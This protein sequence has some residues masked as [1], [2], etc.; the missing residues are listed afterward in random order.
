MGKPP[1]L[2]DQA[3]VG[4]VRP[5]TG[6]RVGLD[7]VRPALRIAADIDAPPVAAAQRRQD[8]KATAPAAL[9]FSLSASMMFTLSSEYSLFS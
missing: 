4:I 8:A 6:E 7:E 9:L 2:R 1:A 5:E 3:E